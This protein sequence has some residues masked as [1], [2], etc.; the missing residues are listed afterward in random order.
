MV[1]TFIPFNITIL[2]IVQTPCFKQIT[3]VTAD[4]TK[5]TRVQQYYT[6]FVVRCNERQETAA[7]YG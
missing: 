2:A 5:T 6:T 7:S 4:S 1:T 3:V